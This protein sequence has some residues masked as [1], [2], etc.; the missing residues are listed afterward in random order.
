MS[1]DAERWSVV[2][3]L[4]AMV[5]NYG[6]G[7][8]QWDHLDK[9]VCAKAASIIRAAEAAEAAGP[10]PQPEPAAWRDVIAERERQRNVEGWTTAH[11]DEHDRGEMAAAGS[12]YAINAAN[13]LHPL[14]QGDGHNEQPAQWPWAPSWWK[15]TTPRR[16]LEKAAALIL[17]EIERIDRAA[18]PD[19]ERA[20]F[21]VQE[22][23]VFE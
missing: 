8:H 11:D 19:A 3:K 6:D 22:C 12:A 7:P 23:F 17:A 15:P 1:T 13:Q 5:R 2:S 16:D 18:T 14:S 9:E 4:E 21:E 20:A 10:A